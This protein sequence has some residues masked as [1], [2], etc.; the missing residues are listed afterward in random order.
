MQEE[1]HVVGGQTSPCQHFHRKEIDPSEN[2]HMRR[3]ELLPRRAL[4]AFWRWGNAVTA[5]DIA[6]GLIGDNVP[7]IRQCSDDSV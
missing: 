1:E 4:A 7:Q 6:D 3:N 5:Q 2:G